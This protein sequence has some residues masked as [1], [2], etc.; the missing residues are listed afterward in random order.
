MAPTKGCIIVDD[1]VDTG[2]TLLHYKSGAYSTYEVVT[3][4]YREGSLVKPDYYFAKKEG[5]WIQFPWE[6]KE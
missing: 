3:M 6:E 5:E 2:E 1:I 4:F